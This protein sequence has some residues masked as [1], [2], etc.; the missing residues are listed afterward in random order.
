MSFSS[1]SE[2]IPPPDDYVGSSVDEFTND[3]IHEFSYSKSISEVRLSI[4]QIQERAQS[5]LAS[6][7]NSTFRHQRSPTSFISPDLSKSEIYRQLDS[8]EEEVIYI[9]KQLA[10]NNELINSAETE[11]S[12][13]LQSLIQIETKLNLLEQEKCTCKYCGI[14]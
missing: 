3:S 6:L 10:L 14:F 2:K 4:Q 8:L 13:L 5:K 12:K 11:N 9:N 7:R 1:D